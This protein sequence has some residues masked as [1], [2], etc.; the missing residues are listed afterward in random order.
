MPFEI[1]VVLKGLL[2]MLFRKKLMSLHGT[3]ICNIVKLLV[4]E[5]KERKEHRG[6]GTK[7]LI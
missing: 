1:Y 4:A 6:G 3:T 2:V 5:G 7:G